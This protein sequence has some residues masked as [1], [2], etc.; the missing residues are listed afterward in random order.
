MVDIMRIVVVIITNNNNHVDCVILILVIIKNYQWLILL[1]HY[2]ELKCNPDSTDIAR[3]N[4]TLQSFLTSHIIS[5]YP[6][7]HKENTVLRIKV[8]DEIWLEYFFKLTAFSSLLKTSAP[9]GYKV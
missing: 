3:Y 6:G 7:T 4:R 9:S 1:L 2:A 8:N 5:D